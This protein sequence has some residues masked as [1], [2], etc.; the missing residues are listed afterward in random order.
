MPGANGGQVIKEFLAQNEVDVL[1]LE[2][3]TEPRLRQCRRR[4]RLPSG[5]AQP[6]HVT[7]KGIKNDIRKA[8]H[9]GRFNLGEECTGTVLCKYFLSDGQIKLKEVPIHGRKIPMHELRQHI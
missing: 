6:M 1:A 2:K 8:V 9:G 4:L 3:R 7:H 5:I